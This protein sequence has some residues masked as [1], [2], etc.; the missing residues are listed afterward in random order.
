M[1]RQTVSLLVKE[2]ASTGGS[3]YPLPGFHVELADVLGRHAE[4]VG[5]ELRQFDGVREGYAGE[6]KQSGDSAVV[7]VLYE[8]KV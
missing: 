2:N 1:L 4:V 5:V 3:G 7:G 6:L 8:P